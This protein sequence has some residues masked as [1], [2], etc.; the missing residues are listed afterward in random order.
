VA[1]QSLQSTQVWNTSGVTA[2]T[3]PANILANNHL[4]A[5]SVAT[6]ESYYGLQGPFA[7]DFTFSAGRTFKWQLIDPVTSEYYSFEI[8][9]NT[10]GS[11][12]RQKNVT[13]YSTTADDSTIVLYEG[14][15]QPQPVT[16]SGTLLSQAQ[17][18]NMIYWYSKRRQVLLIDDLGR[19]I[20]VYFV[21]WEPQRK[22]TKQSP[23]RHD[24]SAQFFIIGPQAVT[25]Q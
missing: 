14:S 13:Q 6:A 3:L 10:G 21:H 15:D 20:W 1:T 7:S 2:V 11:L 18:Q 5:W 25:T 8:N 24:W 17:Y 19:N 16:V 9:P 23:W 22:W 12:T 4:V